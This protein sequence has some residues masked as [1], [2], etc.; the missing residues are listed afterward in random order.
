MTRRTALTAG[1][2]LVLALGALVLAQQ[3]IRLPSS[4]PQLFG[5]SV[6]PAFE[7]WW[8]NP[9]GTHSFLIGYFSRNTE[10][11]VDVPIGPNNKFEPGNPDMGQPTH[12]LP[13][14]HFGMFVVNV[15][16]DFQKTQKI[17][18][19]LT[20]ASNTV[21]IPFHMHTD[22]GISAF[23]STEEASGRRF[24]E[25]PSIRFA[26]AGPAIKGPIGTPLKA[27]ERTAKVGTPMPLD[28]WAEDDGVYTTGTNAPLLADRPPVTWAVTKYRGPGTVKV[29]EG[30]KLTTTKGGKAM[31]AYAGKG[32]TTVSFSEAGDYM[33]HVQLNDYSGQGG[34]GS[35]CC[36]TTAIVKVQVA[37]AGAQ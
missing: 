29:G 13:R 6:T 22:Y 33:L 1:A 12:F 14:R 37:A 10:A 25:P 9:D 19:T 34:G 8:D 36:W 24:N 4:P 3:P 17:T 28:V 15:P 7:G 23:K 18:W 20:V 35:G 2:G 26:E 30:L 5:A 31:Q 11:V 16:K 27:I 32:S 21:S